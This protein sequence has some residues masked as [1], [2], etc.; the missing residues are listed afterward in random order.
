MSDDQPAVSSTPL[1]GHGA[2]QL[3]SVLVD[4]YNAELRDTEGFIGDR[5]SK[6]AFQAIVDDW[7]ERLRKVGEDPLGETPTDEIGKKKLD[8]LLV[9]GVPSGGPACCSRASTATGSSCARS[10]ITRT[11]PD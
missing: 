10:A 1:A 5:A 3:A 4:T 9:D 6:R 11:R 8:K 2:A 7:R